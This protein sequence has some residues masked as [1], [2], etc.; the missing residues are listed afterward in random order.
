MYSVE[1]HGGLTLMPIGLTTPLQVPGVYKMAAL[2]GPPW[3]VAALVAM[4]A[5]VVSVA[6]VSVAVVMVAVVT[7]VA[8][9]VLVVT[10]VAVVT[11][12]VHSSPHITGQCLE[13]NS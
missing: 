8:L 1:V 11:V 12:E 10:D 3:V 7:V 4:M 2:V 9:P 13:A 5:D 6:V